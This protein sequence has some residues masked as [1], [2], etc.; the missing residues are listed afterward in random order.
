MKKNNHDDVVVVHK[1][2]LKKVS[3]SFFLKAFN[4]YIDLNCLTTKFLAKVFNKSELNSTAMALIINSLIL[5]IIFFIFS[6]V[7]AAAVFALFVLNAIALF[8]NYDL[9]N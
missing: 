2:K 5:A 3:E 4:W 6:G 8:I 1:K 9:K 7:I